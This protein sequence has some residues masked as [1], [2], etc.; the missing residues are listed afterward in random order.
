MNDRLLGQTSVYGDERSV[1]QLVL[2]IK[3]IA[4]VLETDGLFDLL[5]LKQVLGFRQPELATL[6][7]ENW[8]AHGNS[9]SM[10]DVGTARHDVD[11]QH[12]CR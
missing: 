2:Q 11:W 6:T 3:W 7:R 8:E 12:S 5:G 4:P 10:W 1:V 9:A